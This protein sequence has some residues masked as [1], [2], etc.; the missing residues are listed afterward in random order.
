MIII[1]ETLVLLRSDLESGSAA[2][3]ASEAF[4]LKH[5]F[6]F[7][8]DVKCFWLFFFLFLFLL[9]SQSKKKTLL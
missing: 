5:N 3:I 2:A 1:E 4:N 6:L 9:F 8:S 7:Y